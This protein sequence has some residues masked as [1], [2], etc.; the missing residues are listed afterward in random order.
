MIK[1]DY[2]LIAS[3]MPTVLTTIIEKVSVLEGIACVT[4]TR[5]SDCIS[6]SKSLQPR[7]IIMHFRDNQ[8]SIKSLLNYT[9]PLKTAVI[10]LTRAFENKHINFPDDATVF[11]QSYEDAIANGISVNI[12]SII[13]L[14]KKVSTQNSLKPN[15][16]LT[17]AA[18][19]NSD[20]NLARYTLELD[21]KVAILHKIKVRIKHLAMHT[22][23]T[24]RSELLSLNQSIKSATG[25]KNHWDDFKIY[26]ESINPDFLKN[27]TNRF[28]VLTGKDLKYCCY[29]KMNM[30]NDDIRHVLG[31][32]Q[33]SVRTHKYRLKR[34]MTLSKEQNLRHYLQSFA[35]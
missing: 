15:T 6:I 12:K 4:A 17:L 21:Q 24:T 11:V 31:I 30:S 13:G 1:N 22:D 35:S 14:L 28:P 33:E 23:L 29:L 8:N 7:V 5:M 26:F 27:L 10:C 32:N 25:D 18:K 3:D 16:S 2:I 19:Q 34:K 20:K 9:T